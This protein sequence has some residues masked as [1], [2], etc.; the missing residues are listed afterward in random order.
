VYRNTFLHGGSRTCIHSQQFFHVADRN[1]KIFHPLKL[2]L[3]F[4]S[5]LYSVQVPH[6]LQ[7]L[8]TNILITHAKENFPLI[9]YGNNSK[10]SIRKFRLGIGRRC[11]DSQCFWLSRSRCKIEERKKQERY[12]ALRCHIN[13]C[14]GSFYFCFSHFFLIFKK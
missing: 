11:I 7:C 4:P 3:L 1:T 5:K 8:Y 6:T 2:H 9:T 13:R 14:T 10:V 12:I